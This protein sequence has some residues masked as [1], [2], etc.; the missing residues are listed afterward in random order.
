MYLKCLL[1]S[2]VLLVFVVEIR[3]LTCIRCSD[4]TC[5]AVPDCP[6]SAV[7]DP[8]G[9]CLLCAK[10]K[11]EIC[12]GPYDLY[13]TCDKGLR[14]AGNMTGGRCVERKARDKDRRLKRRDRGRKRGAHSAGTQTV[15]PR[16]ERRGDVVVTRGAAAD[17]YK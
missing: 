15:P 12:G 6:G 11:Q 16:A 5:P 17:R 14:C 13:G 3:A 7:P 4:F 10:Q 1:V 8:C 2:S 9:C